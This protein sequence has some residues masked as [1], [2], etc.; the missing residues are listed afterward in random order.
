MSNSFVQTNLALSVYYTVY[1]PPNGAQIAYKFKNS[2]LDA[3]TSLTA[4]ASLST[5]NYD[6]EYYPNI[7]L[8]MF[9]RNTS[10]TTDTFSLG[11]FSTNI[12]A[13]TFSTLFVYSYHDTSTI[14]YGDFNP[15]SY[16][17][18]STTHL[19]SWTFSSFIRDSGWS[20][21]NSMGIYTITFRSSGLQFP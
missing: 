5:T 15:N 19:T 2:N 18:D 4:L 12:A 10:T 20:N 8:C 13:S 1:D 16:K 21:T 17:Q 9:K 11:T 7:N 3:L 14:Y 6:Y